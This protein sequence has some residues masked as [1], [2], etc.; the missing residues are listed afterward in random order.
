MWLDLRTAVPALVHVG[1][2]SPETTARVLARSSSTRTM[3]SAT[4]DTALIAV[5]TGAIL[6]AAISR[7]IALRDARLHDLQG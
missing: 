2:S 4:L 6:M 5:D 3:L 1:F 7:L